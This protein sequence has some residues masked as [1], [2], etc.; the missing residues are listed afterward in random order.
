MAI[1][2]PS[3]LFGRWT[4][5]NWTVESCRPRAIL[6]DGKCVRKTSRWPGFFNWIFPAYIVLLMALQWGR[7][8][9]PQQEWKTAKKNIFGREKHFRHTKSMA[10]KKEQVLLDDGWTAAFKSHKIH[11]GEIGMLAPSG[12]MVMMMMMMT[13]HS[14]FQKARAR[15]RS[16]A[17][18]HPRIS[19]EIIF[20]SFVLCVCVGKC[21]QMNMSITPCCRIEQ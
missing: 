20:F 5:R 13:R 17:A 19:F 3:R 7:P 2:I 10:E 15:V 21:M 4:N 1:I 16:S 14:E 11:K 8:S 6:Y 18:R 9:G 12:V